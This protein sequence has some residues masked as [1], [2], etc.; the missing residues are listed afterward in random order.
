MRDLQ[1]LAMAAWLLAACGLV[2]AGLLALYVL[3]RR[4]HAR[5]ARRLRALPWEAAGVLL[6]MGIGPGSFA[7]R[8]MAAI[9]MLG[10]HALTACCLGTRAE[11]VAA[12]RRALGVEPIRPAPGGHSMSTLGWTVVLL[13]LVVL[14]L[15]T[16]ILERALGGPT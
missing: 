3:R 4:G 9:S 12:Y 6:W 5:W 14:G 10:L 15:L 13:L 1:T 11:L 8:I 16:L 7:I 2:V